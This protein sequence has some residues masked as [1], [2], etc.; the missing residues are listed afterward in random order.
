MIG[1]FADI[2]DRKRAEAAVR[3]SEE[4]FRHMADSAPALIWMSDETGQIVFANMHY[5]H[6]FGRPAAEMLGNGWRDIVLPEDLPDLERGF[7]EAFS[8]RK[9]FQ[10]EVRGHDRRGDIRWLRCVGVP[11]FDDARCFLGY[12]GC[13]IDVTEAKVAEE[14]RDL[15]I[16]EFNHRVKN[17]LANVQ[18]IASQTLRKTETATEATHLHL[19]WQEKGGPPVRAP[20]RRGFGT[21]LI[22]RSLAHDP[23]GKVQIDFAPTGAVCKLSAPLL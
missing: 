8:V 16:N 18:S 13:N 1:V 19:W 7:R 21:R 11:R 17:T 23:S 10:A 3:E 4:R 14:R 6:L 22:E 20:S 15:L 9:P 12:T 5:D 2:T